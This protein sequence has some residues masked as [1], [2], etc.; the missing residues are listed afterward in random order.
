MRKKYLETIDSKKDV[1]GFHP[2]NQGFLM[3]GRPT[4]IP[5]TPNLGVLKL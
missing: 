4:F 2:K 1:D 5:C 3:Q